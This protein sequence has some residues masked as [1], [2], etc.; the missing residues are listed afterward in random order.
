MFSTASVILFKGGGR[1]GRAHPLKALSEHVLPRSCQVEGVLY[2]LSRYC[3]GNG[4]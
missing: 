1:R 2:I 4:G 3:L